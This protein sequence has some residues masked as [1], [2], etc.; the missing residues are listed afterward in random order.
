MTQL[1]IILETIGSKPADCLFDCFDDVLLIFLVKKFSEYVSYR[2][3]SN[4]AKKNHS[5]RYWDRH[6][7]DDNARI[8]ATTVEL[9]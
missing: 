9:G 7:F 8:G 5:I 4:F 3:D 6:R 1:A 2:G